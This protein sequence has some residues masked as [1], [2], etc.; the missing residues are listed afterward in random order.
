M[1]KLETKSVVFSDSDSSFLYQ[2]HKEHSSDYIDNVKGYC[3]SEESVEQGESIDTK[4]ELHS[5][6]EK[7]LDAGI[8]ITKDNTDKYPGDVFQEIAPLR[9]NRFEALNFPN[10]AL[11]V[12][13]YNA[14]IRSGLVTLYD[15]QTTTLEEMG[16]TYIANDPYKLCLVTC[17]GS[18]KDA[19]IIASA[20]TWFCGCKIRSRCI[21][22]SS[23]GVQLTSQTEGYIR[24]LCQSVNEYHNAEIFTIRQRLITC[25]LSGSEIRLFATDEAGKAEGYH[26]MDPNAEMMIVVNEGK[27]VSQEIHDALR[28]CTGYN[29]WLEVSSPGESIGFFYN[30]FKTWKRVKVVN[31]FMCPHLSAA[32]REQDKLD[33]GE[34]SPLYR[35]KHLALFT[36]V[37]GETIISRDFVISLLNRNYEHLFK[38]FEISVGI[39]LAA[40]GDETVI[41]F[42]HG[43]KCI[44][45]KAFIEADTET[46]ADILEQT[47]INA[48]IKKDHQ[49]INADD[50]GVGKSIIDKLV[51]RGWNINRVNNQSPAI[52][53]RQFGNRGAENWYRVKRIIEEGFFDVS[54]ISE[55]T[56]DQLCERRYKK[57]LNSGRLFLESKKDAKAEGRKSPDRA[58]ALVLA[59]MFR[60]IDDF[61]EAKTNKIDDRNKLRFNSQ[62][63]L[64]EYYE[65]N[66]QYGKDDPIT[67]T[68]KSDNDKRCFGS[69]NV[70][71]EQ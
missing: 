62:K 54:T 12:S 49:Y 29:Y 33:W 8:T 27:S 4:T 1:I 68:R 39:D 16:L 43:N 61:I 58:D 18:G 51:R 34:D 46:T 30:A 38:D 13:F 22:T 41:T 53:K 36:S 32:E 50:G 25:N 28:R 59:L 69:I 21:V 47:L 6:K 67:W 5:S 24:S 7:V 10:P 70:A 11:F 2:E 48:R 71:L 15:W 42:V 23:S 35:S 57:T 66:I 44:K 37:G 9:N 63:E 56:R 64:L 55:K 52:Y 3:K 65:N 40:G 20:V 19:F 26:P 14:N 31:T 60:S 17:N 45:E